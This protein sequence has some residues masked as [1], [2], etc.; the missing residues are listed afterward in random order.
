M[1]KKADVKR[2]IGDELGKILEPADFKHFKGKSKFLRVVEGGCHII[3]YRILQ[4]YNSDSNEVVWEVEMLG[5]IRFDVVHDWFLPFEKRQKSD[6]KFNWTWG[7]YSKNLGC[8]N[9]EITP[10]AE[11]ITHAAAK[12]A[13]ACVNAFISFFEKYQTIEVLGNKLLSLNDQER[14]F[15]FRTAVENLTIIWLL[16]PDFFEDKKR[17]YKQRLTKLFEVGDPMTEDLFPKFDE[18]I[19]ALIEFNYENHKRIL[20]F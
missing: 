5:F 7:E 20:K 18:L 10:L 9:I 6:L 2:V 13:Q 1:T 17:E 3:E 15:N 19:G 4:G 12:H 11:S 14:A 16:K 8:S